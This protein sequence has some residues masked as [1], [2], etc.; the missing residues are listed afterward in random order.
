[1]HDH[2]DGHDEPAIYHFTKMDDGDEEEEE[3]EEEEERGGEE[4]EEE[5]EDE[6]SE[7]D[8]K[9]E[10]E[11][12]KRPRFNWRRHVLSNPEDSFRRKYRMD[13]S[14]FDKL[15]EVL[16][17]ALARPADEKYTGEYTFGP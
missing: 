2:G 5:Q 11:R 9:E 4:E 10:E 15:V 17:P 7:V 14:S 16:R 6:E 13:E 1:M 12:R 3:L 8:D